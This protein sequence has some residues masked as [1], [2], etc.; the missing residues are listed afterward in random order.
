MTHLGQVK[1]GRIEQW[2]VMNI[3]LTPE[4]Y[5]WAPTTPPREQILQVSADTAFSAKQSQKQ[6]VV[7][8]NH[9]DFKHSEDF[10]SRLG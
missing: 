8:N 9:T 7:V 2:L 3:Q 10:E 5:V 6:S 4:T 1:T